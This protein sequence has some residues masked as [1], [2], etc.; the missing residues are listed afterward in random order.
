MCGGLGLWGAEGV[1]WDRVCA[2]ISISAGL[3]CSELGVQGGCEVLCG[4]MCEVEGYVFE[5]GPKGVWAGCVRRVWDRWVYI[6]CSVDVKLSLSFY[7]PS[8]SLCCRHPP[9][10]FL[11]SV[12]KTL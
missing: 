9:S 11:L 6:S 1:V 3:R 5:M 10:N 2:W 12:S 8:K 4:W 7:V